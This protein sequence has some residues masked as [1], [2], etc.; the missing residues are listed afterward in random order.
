M[1]ILVNGLA[2]IGQARPVPVPAGAILAAAPD[3]EEYRNRA[4]AA[5]DEHA[6]IRAAASAEGRDLTDEEVDQLDELRSNASRWAKLAAAAEPIQ[7]PGA[8]RRTAPLADPPVHNR[9]A[10]GAGGGHLVPAAPIDRRN[11][12]RSLGDFAQATFCHYVRHDDSAT[13]RLMASATTFGTEGVGGDG[14]FAVPPEFSTQIWQK[15]NSQEN[16]MTRCSGMPMASNNMTFPKDETT[17]WQTSGGVLAYWESEAAA[18]TQTKPQFLQDTIRLAKLMALVPI[19]EELLEDAPAIEGWLNLKAPAKMVARINTAIVRGTGAGQPL[20]ILNSTSI[21]SVAKATSQD[22]STVW[23]QNVTDMWGRIYAP[24]RAGAIWLINQDVE[25]YLQ[26]MA[27]DPE[28]STKVP[29]YLGP[30]G[31]AGSPYATLQGRPV[32]PI[33][34]CSSAG[35]QGDIILVNLGE[36]IVYSKAGQQEPRQDVSMHLFFDQALMAF[37]FMFRLN[38]MPLWTNTITR[39]NGTNTLSW[40]VTLDARS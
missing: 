29:V 14:G 9:A 5:I 3:A 17:P 2:D 34:P 40:A 1:T 31:I 26:R 30:N 21:I 23:F 25:P 28:A 36:Y 32:V 20:G 16:L 27:F 8:G 24:L 15:I 6:R 13:G 35:T 37:R 4:Q 22:A 38:G 18:V 33:E 19:S 7:L 12:F 11:G 10:P 39:E